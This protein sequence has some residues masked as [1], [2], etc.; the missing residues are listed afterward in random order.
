MINIAMQN[1][2]ADMVSYVCKHCSWPIMEVE[3]GHVTTTSILH[4]FFHV[5]LL[6]KIGVYKS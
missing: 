1:A 2:H 5:N 3:F 6:I 4:H